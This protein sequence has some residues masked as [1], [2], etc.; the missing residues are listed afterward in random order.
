M[1]P[2]VATRDPEFW[3]L[4]M[5]I[6]DACDST[7]SLW[8][9]EHKAPFDCDGHRSGPTEKHCACESPDDCPFWAAYRDEYRAK[10][11]AEDE[12]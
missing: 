7:R 8:V 3:P 6:C 12:L 10:Q 2:S 9:T 11:E 5:L 1:T 4:A